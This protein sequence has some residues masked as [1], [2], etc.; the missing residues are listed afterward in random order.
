M[1]SE[2]SA[3]WKLVTKKSLSGKKT[4]TQKSKGRRHSY[5][6]EGEDPNQHLLWSLCLEEMSMRQS[7]KRKIGLYWGRE[8]EEV[9]VQHSLEQGFPHTHK[10]RK[11]R[12]V[13]QVEATCLIFHTQDIMKRQENSQFNGIKVVSEQFPHQQKTTLHFISNRTNTAKKIF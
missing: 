10:Y 2:N 13:S 3:S 1:K 12:N 4:G 9:G 11:D 8:A 6:K 7:G 5:I